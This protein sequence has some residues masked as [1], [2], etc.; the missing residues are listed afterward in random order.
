MSNDPL[1]GA[2]PDR[3]QIRSMLRTCR[4]AFPVPCITFTCPY[5]YYAARFPPS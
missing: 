2:V 5:A 1:G 4:N 3:V